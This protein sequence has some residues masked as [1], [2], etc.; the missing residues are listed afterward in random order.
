MVFVPAFAGLGAPHWDMQA[1][2]A[3]LGLS[4]DTS[5]AQ[6][7]RAAL[8]SIALQAYDLVEIMEKDS[9][10]KLEVLRV[11]GGAAANSFLMQYQADILE[12]TVERPAN[13]G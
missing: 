10:Q 9:G 5:A 7:T 12:R 1:R 13:L 4:R 8:K 11:D 3:I 6:I 2:G